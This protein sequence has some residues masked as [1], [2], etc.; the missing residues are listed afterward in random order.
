VPAALGR[1]QSIADPLVWQ[2]QMARARDVVTDVELD[3]LTAATVGQVRAE[4]AAGRRIA[5]AWSGGK[6]SQALRYVMEQAGVPACMVGM[7]IGLEWP[8][9]LRWQTDHMPPGCEVVTVALDLPWLIKHPS[10]LFPQGAHGPRWFSLVQHR[11]QRVYFQREGLELLALGRRRKDG[12]FVGRD[13]QDRYTDRHGL[14]RWSPMADWTHEQ[15]FALIDR[16]NIPL[17][18]CYHWPR[19]FQV[20]TGPWPARQWTTSPDHGWAECWA[21]D[22][23]VVRAAAATLPAAA[24]WMSRNGKT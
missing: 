2:E 20:G 23:T 11:A 15:V 12:N 9:M 16:H 6:D 22:S 1:K 18:P 5:Y 4:L 13:G 10:M 3:A 14:T 17:P 8:A 7:T 19:G 24:D 21:I